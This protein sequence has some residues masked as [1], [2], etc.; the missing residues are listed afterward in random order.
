MRLEQ[1]TSVLQN[2]DDLSIG[3]EQ[4]NKIYDFLHSTLFLSESTHSNTVIPFIRTTY[5][6]VWVSHYLKKGYNTVD[7][8]VR[9]LFT[10]DD[11]FDW[12]QIKRTN[13]EQVMMEESIRHGVGENGYSVPYR[14]RRSRLSMF[15]ITSNLTGDDWL[16]FIDD[17]KEDLV[18]ISHLLHTIALVDSGFDDAGIP[19]LSK[20]ELEV[21]SLSADGKDYREIADVLEISEHTTRGYLKAVREKLECRSMAQAVAKSIRLRLFTP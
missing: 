3:L 2:A 15:S 7:P 4:L 20:R 16:D 18:S 5:P 21:L 1:A 8:V 17:C 6:D 10:T 13:S 12:A 9:T 11:P 14:D 19:I